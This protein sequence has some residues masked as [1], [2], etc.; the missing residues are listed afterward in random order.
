[1]NNNVLL[2][3]IYIIITLIFLVPLFYLISVE[4]FQILYII[5]FHINRQKN[6]KITDN[7]INYI[8]NLYIKRNQWFLCISML[9]S[10]YKNTIQYDYVTI[11]IYL[12]YCYEKLN[13]ME[14][15]KFYYLQVLSYSPS[16]IKAL[17]RLAFF[18]TLSNEVHQASKFN[19]R[20]DLLKNN[21]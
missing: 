6:M 7:Q 4:L 8:I 11:S 21:I 13:Y 20:I 15:A 5:Y 18:Y 9:E 16:N 14:I 10:L 17:S 12:A 2:F 3:Y 1:M 19:K